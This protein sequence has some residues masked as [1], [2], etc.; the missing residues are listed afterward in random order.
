MTTFAGRISEFAGILWDNQAMSSHAVPGS[1]VVTYFREVWQQRGAPPADK[2]ELHES[3]VPSR[4]DQSS[5]L[6]QIVAVVYAL[7]LGQSFLQ[8]PGLFEH[9]LR[10][11]NRTT[12]LAILAVF[13]GVAWEYLSYSL[14][15]GRFPYRVRWTNN[16]KSD[17]GTEEGRFGVDLAIALAYAGLLLTALRTEENPAGPLFAFFIILII[18]DGLNFASDHLAMFKWDVP[19]Y[20]LRRDV[21]LLSGGLLVLYWLYW[22]IPATPQAL[23]NQLFLVATTILIIVRD[24]HI[25]KIAQRSFKDRVDSKKATVEQQ[26][27]ASADQASEPRAVGSRARIYAAGPLGFTPYGNEYHEHDVLG[28]LESAGFEPADPWDTPADAKAVYAMGDAADLYDL[29]LANQQVGQNNIA[30]IQSSAGVLAILDGTDVDSG[31]ASEIG[32]AAA[33]GKRVVGLRL[34]TRVTGD[35]RAAQVNLQVEAFIKQNGGKVVRTLEDAIAALQ[36][37]FPA[38]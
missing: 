24:L 11:V 31:T 20:R 30:L 28:R 2:R 35:N 37:L 34:D 16:G 14:N 19:A 13:V 12:V 3:E 1:G 18:I 38:N 33:L 27:V 29:K 36:E 22:V 23:G 10:A 15:M 6:V 9:P 7:V 4:S 21:P 32:Y 17:T 26:R 8:E 5:S 25:R